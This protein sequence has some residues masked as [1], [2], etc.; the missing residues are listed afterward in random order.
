MPSLKNWYFRVGREN[1]HAHGVIYGHERLADGMI[2]T[3]SRIKDVKVIDEDGNVEIQTRNTLYKANLKE[4]IFD[5][6][7]DLGKSLF[8]DFDSLR[9]KFDK[10]YDFPEEIKEQDGIVIELSRIADFNFVSCLANID[11]KRYKELEPSIH[12]GMFED[13]VLLRIRGLSNFD[14]RYFPRNVGSIDFYTWR[15]D[16]K[17]YIKNSSDMEMDITVFDFKKTLKPGEIILVP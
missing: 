1:A 11:G 12:L 6:F 7:D 9:E 13:S 16:Y 15:T 5:G 4:S 2:V 8:E 3:T 14:C 10:E 17:T